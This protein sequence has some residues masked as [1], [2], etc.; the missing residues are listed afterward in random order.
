MTQPPTG[1]EDSSVRFDTH[2]SARGEPRFIIRHDDTFYVP[3]GVWEYD[4]RAET[5]E[6][7]KRAIR[8]V[9]EDFERLKR[10]SC[11]REAVSIPVELLVY[12]DPGT[13]TWGPAAT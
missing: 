3:L 8:Q 12:S 6:K 9:A 7:Q 1:Q 2:V 10:E 11:G 13:Q 5:S 4:P